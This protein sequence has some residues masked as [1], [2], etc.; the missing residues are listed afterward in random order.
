M[1]DDR[2]IVIVLAPDSFKGSLG[3]RDACSAI[4]GG[5]R[6]V[7]PNAEIRARPMADGGE[8]TIDAVLAGGGER[9]AHD[10]TGAGGQRRTAGYGMI[11]TPEGPTAIVEAAEIVG[12]TDPAGLS[13]AVWDR[14]TTGMGELLRAL[15][16]AGT[17]RFMIGLGGTST[18]D[19]G[20][21]MLAVL[22]VRFRDRAGQDVT[23]TLAGL[24]RVASVDASALDERLASCSLT[25]LSDV[26]NPLCGGL[27]ATSVFGPQKGIRV[28]DVG[29]ADDVLKRYADLVEG[30]FGTR[31]AHEP[32]AGAAGGLGFAA[33][34]LGGLSRSGAEVVAD[35]IGLDGALVGA[36]WVLT[37]EGKS[38]A[39]TLAGKAP[40][41]VARRAHAARVPATLLSGAV[42]R[43]ALP[44]LGKVFAGCFALPEGPMTLAA[45]IE[46]A[47]SLLADRAEQL[48]H[49]WREAR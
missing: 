37:G 33:H 9:K 38:D 11:S 15:L 28:E 47:P 43:A 22:G 18:N 35:L 30:A 31:A 1:Q 10:V 19:G 41:V 29:A 2:P 12:L 46:N 24:A 49:L 39:Q 20:A 5:L 36:S 26:T 42:D 44:D 27:G 21:G 45:C 16:D 34:L 8:G 17:R 48:A 4:A 13:V 40:F 23:P 3:A 32:G 25:I 6:R 14:S 7:F